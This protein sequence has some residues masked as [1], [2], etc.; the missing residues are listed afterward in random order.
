LQQGHSGLASWQVL[1]TWQLAVVGFMQVE[2]PGKLALL[3]VVTFQIS[4]L[5]HALSPLHF[6]SDAG[7]GG[8]VGAGLHFCSQ[9]FRQGNV[10]FV[11]FG[12]ATH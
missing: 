3:W 12:S 9:S 7:V 4:P 6:P 2:M 10:P 1:H 5:V 8:G 11:P